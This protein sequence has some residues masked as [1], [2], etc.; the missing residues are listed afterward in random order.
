MCGLDCAR[1]VQCRNAGG[2]PLCGHFCP[3]LAA[4][5]GASG[6][7]QEVPIWLR[8]RG[9][10]LREF[11]ATFQRIGKLPDGLV[12]AF[13]GR[14]SDE[15]SDAE[16]V[17]APAAGDWVPQLERRPRQLRQPGPSRRQRPKLRLIGR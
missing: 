10:D 7:A 2:E 1:A 14:P 13:F 16:D 5:R 15:E 3:A 12:V 4:A 11:T 6:L 17:P 8:N 9:G